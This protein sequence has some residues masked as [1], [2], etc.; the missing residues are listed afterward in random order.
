MPLG[1][2]EYSVNSAAPYAPTDMKP[3]WPSASWPRYPVVRLRLA[4]SIMFIPTIITMPV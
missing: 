4:V 1:R 2:P 3:A